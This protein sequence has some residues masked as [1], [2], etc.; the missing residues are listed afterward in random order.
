MR[1]AGAEGAD[2]TIEAGHALGGGE[3]RVAPTRIELALR[4]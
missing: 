1:L 2:R 4:E 3:V